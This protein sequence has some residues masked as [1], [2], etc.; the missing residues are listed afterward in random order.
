MELFGALA[1]RDS[2]ERD[3]ASNDGRINTCR[4]CIAVVVVVVDRRWEYSHDLG[5][6]ELRSSLLT[7]T[8]SVARA[9]ERLSPIVRA[10]QLVKLLL[11]PRCCLH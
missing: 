3:I 11:L 2:I 1:S 5:D 6:D 8:C 4:G 9:R 7:R 10:T